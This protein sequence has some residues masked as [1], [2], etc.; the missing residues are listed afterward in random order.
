MNPLRE[1]FENFPVANRRKWRSQ[2]WRSKK[3]TG[4]I[5]S[6]ANVA[7]RVNRAENFV[8]NALLKKQQQAGITRLLLIGIVT[9]RNF[10]LPVRARE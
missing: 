1:H 4:K 2:R 3:F 10:Y 8:K 5:N 7:V 9:T 6:E